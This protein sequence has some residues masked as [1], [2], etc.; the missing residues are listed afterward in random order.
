ME[1]H[2]AN[3][4]II[5]DASYIRGMN[6]DGAPLRTICE[7]G[8][9]IVLIDTLIYELCS[10]ANSAQ[11][12]A[13]MRKLRGCQDAI[14][15]WEHVSDMFKF[16]L[17][18]NRPYGDP[19]RCEITKNMRQK[20]ANNSQWSPPDIE[21]ERRQ[22]ESRDML[23]SL[24]R[25]TGF[26]SFPEKTE[27]AIRKAPHGEEAVQY[28]YDIVNNPN[29]IRSILKAV[30][31]I[32]DEAGEPWVKLQNPNKVNETWLTWHFCKSVLAILCDCR[33]REDR[34]LWKGLVNTKHDIN[35]LVSLAF[36]DAIASCETRGEMS[37]YRRWM[38]G[39]DSKPLISGYE[40]DQIDPI[41]DQLKR[42]STD[43]ISDDRV[44]NLPNRPISRLFGA[45]Q[46]GGPALT[47]EEMEQAIADGA[48]EE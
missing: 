10:T 23:N 38:F 46:H 33:H 20:L 18:Q 27:E 4:R 17:E 7:Q 32:F 48:C 16:E 3:P 6:A 42:G 25:I 35:Y 8:G 19:L 44:G 29:T 21:E 45:L 12:P 37:Y 40:K 22:R 34:T 13:S 2:T 31:N 36:A 15:V 26:L 24:K 9:R 41:M 30:I 5:I 11:W 14:E 39:D 43:K 47:L 1:K 28:C